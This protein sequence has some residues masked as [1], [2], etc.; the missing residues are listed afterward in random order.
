MAQNQFR[1]RFEALTR[2]ER[3]QES[4]IRLI[5]FS[6]RWRKTHRADPKLRDRINALDGRIAAYSDQTY[7]EPFRPMTPDEMTA[8]IRRLDEADLRRTPREEGWVC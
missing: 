6:N 8:R 2:K 1:Q 4:L 7:P 5:I 3:L